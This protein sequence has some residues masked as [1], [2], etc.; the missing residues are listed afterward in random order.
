MKDIN[1][2]EL[3]ILDVL[4]LSVVAFYVILIILKFFRKKIGNQE[5]KG[6]EGSSDVM[7]DG[8]KNK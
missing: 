7:E 2:A 6:K 5:S 3:K 1:K 8:K 4:F